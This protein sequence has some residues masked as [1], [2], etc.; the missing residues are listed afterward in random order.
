MGLVDKTAIASEQSTIPGL[1]QPDTVSPGDFLY[2]SSLTSRHFIHHCAQFCSSQ[3]ANGQMAN[4]HLA[5]LS[6]YTEVTITCHS[7]RLFSDLTHPQHTAVNLIWVTDLSKEQ[8]TTRQEEVKV[9]FIIQYK[10]N[11]IKRKCLSLGKILMPTLSWKKKEGIS[12]GLYLNVWTLSPLQTL[13][14][15]PQNSPSPQGASM[16]LFSQ[17]SRESCSGCWL[18]RTPLIELLKI[19]CNKET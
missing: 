2:V 15:K 4:G 5:T 18:Q 3:Q 8:K 14:S 16:R 6:S 1:P 13:L 7:V 10:Y 9:K 17:T 19:H 12:V 11:K